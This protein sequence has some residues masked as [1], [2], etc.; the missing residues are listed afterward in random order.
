MHKANLCDNAA[1][2]EKVQKHYYGIL[3]QFPDKIAKPSV[4]PLP[5]ETHAFTLYIR[6]GCPYCEAAVNLVKKLPSSVKYQI[7]AVNDLSVDKK[8][9]Q[10]ALSQNT[11]FDR[12]HNTYPIVF[13]QSRFLGGYSDLQQLLSRKD[14]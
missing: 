6:N 14:L 9:L 1:F 3:S 2:V 7:F 11:N 8:G 4:I 5:D 12:K 10:D 13:T